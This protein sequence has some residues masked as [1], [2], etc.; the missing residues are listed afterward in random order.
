MRYLRDK[1]AFAPSVSLF[2]R[3]VGGLLTTS[4]YPTTR[5]YLL[6]RGRNW[7][8]EYSVGMTITG[9]SHEELLLEN[10]EMRQIIS[11]GL[12]KG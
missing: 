7:S 6:L 9:C 3:Q 12:R 11:K 5:S 8:E 2:Q 1:G 4:M 10:L